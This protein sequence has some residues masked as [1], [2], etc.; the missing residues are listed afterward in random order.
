M[1]ESDEYRDRS[2][3]PSAKDRGWSDTSR[4]LDGWTIRRLDDAVCGLHHTREDEEH[5]FFG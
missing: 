3:R 5:I 2:R 1:A 4:V